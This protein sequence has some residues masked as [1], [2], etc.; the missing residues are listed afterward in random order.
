MWTQMRKM[1][2]HV[3]GKHSNSRNWFFLAHPTTLAV[4]ENS[5]IFRLLRMYFSPSVW[6]TLYHPATL[7]SRQ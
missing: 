1:D 5:S 6:A 4:T 7:I 2:K 3:S